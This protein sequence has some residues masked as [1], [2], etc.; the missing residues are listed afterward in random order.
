MPWCA[1]IVLDTADI[2]RDG[3]F[4]AIIV[5]T[6]NC[7]STIPMKTWLRLTVVAITVGGGF[8][9]FAG[10]LQALFQLPSP[11][12]FPLLIVVVFLGL[13]GY[14]TVSGLMF[15]HDSRLTGPIVA[16]LAIQI[17]WV[18]SPV[19][20]YKFEAGLSGFV[21]VGTLE[22]AW[23]GDLNFYSDW[24]LG[25]KWQFSLL[26]D[27]PWRFGVNLVALAVLILFWRIRRTRVDRIPATD[28]AR[29]DPNPT[30][31]TP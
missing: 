13:Y 1:P 7:P 23:S 5:L 2:V 28:V 31:D 9:G 29:A 15:V 26:Q 16:A 3:D 27:E 30:T 6:D 11:K 17:P 20:A 10:T 4:A 8:T 22:K 12:L 24:L 25:S 21:G 14:V 19:I 18:G